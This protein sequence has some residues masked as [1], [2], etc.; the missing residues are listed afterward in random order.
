M[1]Y[2][3]EEFT[4]KTN[5]ILLKSQEL[6][7]E[8]HCTQL[9]PVHVALALLEDE[10]SL[11][12][13]IY[14]KAGGDV[15]K[16]ETGFKRLLSKV[17]QQNPPPNDISPNHLFAQVLRSAVRH[18]KN[19]GD[20]HLA[21]DHLILGL[22]DDPSILSVLG[23]SGANKEQVIS[24]VKEMRGNKKITSKTAESTYEALN[25]YGHDLVTQAQQGKLDPVIGRDDEIRR[26]IRVLSRRTKNNP[27]LI[28]EP[29]VGKTAVVEGLAQRIVRGDIP[30][31]LNAR[32]IALDMGALIAGAKYRGDFEE[33]LKA[34]LKE[35]KDSN[36]GIILFIDEIHLVLG[37]GKTDGAMDAANLLKPMLARGELR[38]IGA[39]TLDEYRQYVEKDPAFERRFQ[40]V[41]VNEPTVNDTISILRGLK[42]RYETHHGVRITD[43]ALVVA[44]Q[45]SH[46][47]ITNR[48]LPDK[49]ID[50]VDEACA[51]TRVQLNSQ[52]EAIDNLERRRLQLEVEA[53]ALEKEEDEGSKVRLASVKDELNNIKDELQPLQAKYQKERSRVDK[54]R[55]LRKKL[56]DVKVKLSDAERR[57]DTQLAADLKYYVIPD[58]EKQIAQGEVER[59]ESK[60]DCLVSETVTPE[61]IADVVARWTGI[62]VSK[63]S[64]TEKQRLL[65]LGEHLHK[66]VVGQDEAVDAVADAVLRSKSGLARENQPLG[67][68]LFLGPT[69]VGKTELAKALA[70]ELFDDEKH[71]VRIDMSEYMESHA[72]SRLIGAPPG[73]VGY[74]QGG[75][76]TEAVRRRPY[77]VVLFDEVEKAHQQVWN[78][79]LQVLD[80]GR[81]TDGQG[82]TV[83]FTNTVIIMTSNLGSQYILNEQSG[84]ENSSSLSQGVKDKVIN[85]CKK[86][87][88]PEF[89]NR[90]DDMIVFSP[91]TKDNLRNIITLQLASVEKRLQAQNMSMDVDKS[92]LDLIISQAYDPVFGARPLKR[93]LEQKITTALSKLILSGQFHEH[94]LC[95]VGVKD[96][97]LTFDLQDEKIQNSNTNRPASPTK[98]QKTVY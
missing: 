47:Y 32:V 86:H 38:C 29:G 63:L 23:D 46:R 72:V 30:D 13:S 96:H 12:K 62:P 91:L 68:F 51:N 19:N 42:E 57:Y 90:L 49:A 60:K 9:A 78:V 87:F 73:Y 65:K 53:A 61:Q 14:E 97:Q 50:L 82:R 98:K 36:G 22:L 40:Q 92:A 66:R 25:K 81:L 48:F 28:G 67:S 6:A 31:N 20:S 54:V 93:F 39:T 5:S 2:N 77:S 55:E 43:T 69:G 10:D 58:L 24:A 11:A 71:M 45:L 41:Y 16:I 27:V 1:S 15:G 84:Q 8:K 95:K 59:K 64:Q 35:V 26:V 17:P 37:A 76:L 88:R 79:L 21:L 44:A 52:P 7:R 83:D 70:F 75:Q 80:D 94:Q 3:P 34:V 18:Q 33:R 89:L 74:D 85:E 56:E 4:D